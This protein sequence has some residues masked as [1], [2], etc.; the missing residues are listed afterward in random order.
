MT[1]LAVVIAGVIGAPPTPFIRVWRGSMPPASAR[2]SL[3][4]V[5]RALDDGR[6]G[7]SVISSFPRGSPKNF[8][9][10]GHYAQ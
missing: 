3:V 9:D 2:D 1:T 6:R 10:G 4:P 8:T 5:A 7:T